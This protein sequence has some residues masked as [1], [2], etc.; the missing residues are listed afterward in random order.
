MA[1]EAIGDYIVIKEI[2][3]EKKTESGIVYV[4]KDDKG[5]TKGLV[6]SSLV[7]GIPK[8]RT[9]VVDS[10]KTAK[11]TY[12]NEQYLIVCKDYVLAFAE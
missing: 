12:N 6:T 11:V 10:Y 7:D 4:T 9:V 5:T 2:S 8:G 1:L 3:D